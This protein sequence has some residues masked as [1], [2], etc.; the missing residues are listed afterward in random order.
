MLRLAGSRKELLSLPPEITSDVYRSLVKSG[1]LV[2]SR[3]LIKQTDLIVSGYKDLREEAKGLVLKYRH[4]IENYIERHPQFLR[5]YAP[6]K[7]DPFAPKIINSMIEAAARTNLGP[8]AS[9]AG[10][11]ADCVG[12]GLLPYSRNVI[13]ENGG[14]IFI[15]ST[16]KR[17]LLLLSENSDLIGLKIMLPPSPAPIGVCTSSGKSGHSLSFG[18]ADAVMIIAN[19]AALADAAATAVGNVIKRPSD[20]EKGIKRAKEIGVN[21]VI[22]LLGEYMGAWGQIELLELVSEVI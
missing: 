22:I 7:R 18:K 20:I 8:M 14:D 1:D 4:Q 10:A 17:D 5:S 13:V 12:L 15:H 19:C 9:V 16:V 6:L 21:G 11:I 2:T 3:I